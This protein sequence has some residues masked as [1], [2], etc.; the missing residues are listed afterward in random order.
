MKSLLRLAA[1]GAIVLAGCGSLGTG[2]ERDRVEQPQLLRASDV[3]RYREGS[4]ERTFLEWWRAL[5]FASGTQAV[6]HYASE[7]EVNPRRLQKAVEA[8]VD[9]LGLR[10]RPKVLDVVQHDDRATIYVLFTRAELSPNGRADK[11]RTPRA[12]DLV[13]EDGSWKLADNGYVERTLRLAEKFV[14]EATKG[15]RRDSGRGQ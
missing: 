14:E 15:P 12:F 9:L 5:Q 10:A 13:R 6:R 7:V 1:G 4:A 11:V 2:E 3:E 8:G